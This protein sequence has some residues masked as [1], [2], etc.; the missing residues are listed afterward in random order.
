MCPV[1]TTSIKEGSS[2]F[3]VEKRKAEERIFHRQSSIFILLNSSC[4]KWD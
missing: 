3:M 1:M 4:K 2:V